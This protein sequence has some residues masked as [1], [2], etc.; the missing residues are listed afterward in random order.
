M[1]DVDTSTP[2]AREHALRG[3]LPEDA[4]QHQPLQQEIFRRE[5]LPDDSQAEIEQWS[6][7][8]R[9]YFYGA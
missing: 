9:L 3:I 5:C 8:R 4:K 7:A 6:R 2:S 1:T